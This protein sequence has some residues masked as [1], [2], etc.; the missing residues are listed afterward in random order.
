MSKIIVLQSGSCAQLNPL[1]SGFAHGFGIFD[2]IEPLQ[3]YVPKPGRG[4][5]NNPNNAFNKIN[6]QPIGIYALTDD[7]DSKYVFVPL[8]LAQNLLK[9]DENQ[10]SGIEIAVGDTAVREEILRS[11]KT[12]LFF[13]FALL[14]R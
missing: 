11:L 5:I 13:K 9:Y 8:R 4:Y 7:V 10:I 14:L 12:N 3:I 6:T 1:H 2:F